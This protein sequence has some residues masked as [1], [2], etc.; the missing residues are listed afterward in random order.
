M[1]K[2]AP[3]ETLCFKS[4]DCDDFS[5]LGATLFEAVEIDSAIGFFSNN[6]SEY[7]AMALVQL[8]ALYGYGSW[9][10]DDLTSYGLGAGNWIIIE[11]QLPIDSQDDSWIAQWGLDV[12][13]ALD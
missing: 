3:V 7:H 10:Y 9:H 8:D 12:A 6:Q 5:N 11:A 13:A 2:S 4:G 1:Q